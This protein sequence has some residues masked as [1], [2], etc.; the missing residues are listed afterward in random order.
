MKYRNIHEMHLPFQQS[1]RYHCIAVGQSNHWIVA[2]PKLGQFYP[3]LTRRDLSF[4]YRRHE[5][6]LSGEKLIIE[7][8]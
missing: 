4:C 6:M 8:S 5:Q 3:L 2:K 7:H 1:V